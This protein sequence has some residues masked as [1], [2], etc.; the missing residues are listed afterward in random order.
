MSPNDLSE[1]GKLYMLKE[2]AKENNI[3]PMQYL[4]SDDVK[5]VESQYGCKMVRSVYAKKYGE[6]LA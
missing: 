3:T 5:D 2:K 6:Y 1:S 4:Y